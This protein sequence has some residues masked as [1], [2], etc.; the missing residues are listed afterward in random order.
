MTDSGQS[1]TNLKQS[2][3][4]RGP[5]WRHYRDSHLFKLEGRKS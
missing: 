5:P 4:I 1:I 3:K 2:V